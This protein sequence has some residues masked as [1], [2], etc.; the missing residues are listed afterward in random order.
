[1][2]S[3]TLE[4]KRAKDLYPILKDEEI[5]ECLKAAKKNV[6]H[7]LNNAKLHYL[8]SYLTETQVQY[9]FDYLKKDVVSKLVG[10]IAHFVYWSVFGGFN[11]MPI[12]SYHME[13]LF[14]TV[15]ELLDEIK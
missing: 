14:K 15:M 9:T 11:K 8:K 10:V 7:V 3:N 12:D 5:E 1:M 2:I 6:A 13:S 4:F